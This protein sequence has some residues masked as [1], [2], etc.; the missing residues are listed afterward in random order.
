MLCE[1]STEHPLNT[2]NPHDEIRL[3]NLD[4]WGFIM[5]EQVTM[6]TYSVHLLP[7]G[8][9]TT[10]EFLLSILRSHLNHSVKERMWCESFMLHQ[11]TRKATGVKRWQ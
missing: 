6:K 10:L 1:H 2:L 8:F 5:L 9:D 7:C 11:D 3:V 4:V